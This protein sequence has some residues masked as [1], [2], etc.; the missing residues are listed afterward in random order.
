MQDKVVEVGLFADY[1]GGMYRII[2]LVV[3]AFA[4]I[5][6][7]GGVLLGV[8]DQPNSG[9]E[10]GVPL[11][12]DLNPFDSDRPIS[13]S[14]GGQGSWDSIVLRDDGSSQSAA[15]FVAS[16]IWLTLQSV[17]VCM[18]IDNHIMSGFEQGVIV[19]I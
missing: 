11:I 3:I 17:S 5:H 4:P 15:D 10:N 6:C 2:F 8:P 16:G 12:A 14:H 13:V 1:S 9:I 19:P 7:F 18:K